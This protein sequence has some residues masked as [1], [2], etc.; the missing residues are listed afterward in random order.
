MTSVQ[1][2]ERPGHSGLAHRFLKQENPVY[3]QDL[4]RKTSRLEAVKKLRQ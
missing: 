4:D 2:E 3:F 1:E